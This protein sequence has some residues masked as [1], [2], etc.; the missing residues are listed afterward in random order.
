MRIFVDS[1]SCPS[2]V[3]EIIVKAA[4]RTKSLSFFVANHK[5]PHGTHAYT[6]DIIVEEGKDKA[7]DYIAEHATERDIAVTRDILLAERLVQ[8]KVSVVNDRG[9]L[10]TAENIRERVS[11]RNY[12]LELAQNGLKTEESGTFGKKELYLFANAF[13]SLITRKLKGEKDES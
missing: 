1:D 11:I 7:D 8:N 12:M 6:H 4:E 13:D 2:Q 9:N 3:R 5:I 10:Y